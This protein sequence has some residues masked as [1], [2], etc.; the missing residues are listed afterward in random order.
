MN[1]KTLFKKLCKF[2]RAEALRRI[3]VLEINEGNLTKEN[4]MPKADTITAQLAAVQSGEQAVL[5][6]A[7]G[8]A[9]DD[10]VADQKAA[11]SSVG[12][13][14]NDIDNAKAAQKATDDQAF[15]DMQAADAKALADSQA[16]DAQAATDAKTKADTALADLKS[17]FDAISAAK[18]VEDGVVTGMQ[19]NLVAFQTALNTLAALMP[20]A[21]G[22]QLSQ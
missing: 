9:Y 6:A 8:Q 12:F 11:D 17:Q 5:S 19:S 13:T 22:S 4:Q 16:S 14:Q 7:I 21:P 20:V 2:G 15:A 3:Q 1:L 10:G 18:S